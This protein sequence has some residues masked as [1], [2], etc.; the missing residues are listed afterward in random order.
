MSSRL[1][2]ALLAT[3]MLL[4]AMAM[5]RTPAA[6]RESSS[7][8]ARRRARTTWDSVF[9]AAQAERGQVTYARTCQ[10][11]HTATLAG[12][13]ESP[14]LAGGAFLSNWSGQSLHVLHDRILSTMPSDTPGVYTRTEMADVM[15]YLLSF[16][17]FPAGTSELPS[18][19]DSLK[20]IVLTTVKP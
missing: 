15:A 17:G 20:S 12:A 9:S 18:S 5:M 4:P 6:V 3:L 19:S 1:R 14:A 7:S 8:E 13:D 10:R 2:G 16:N 11:C